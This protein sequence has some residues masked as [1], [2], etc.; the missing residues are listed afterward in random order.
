MLIRKES[1]LTKI[2]HHYYGFSLYRDK[3]SKAMNAIQGDTLTD[4][5]RDAV[6]V[7]LKL[8]REE[9]EQMEKFV[10]GEL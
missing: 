7:N 4:R 1:L 5:E 2:K 3:L 8:M 6:L 9:I 10:N